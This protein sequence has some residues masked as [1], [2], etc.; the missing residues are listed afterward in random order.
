MYIDSVANM[1]GKI[2]GDIYSK[3]IQK[4]LNLDPL[5]T[6][7]KF[8][9]ANVKGANMVKVASQWE[10]KDTDL[11][12][13]VTGQLIHFLGGDYEKVIEQKEG[14]YSNQIIM[15][16]NEMNNMKTRKKLQQAKLKNIGQPKK[17]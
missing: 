17:E 14:S 15:K 12:I 10:E 3:R 8:K 4:A 6:G 16:Q 7:V 5:K 2:N 9:S 1:N 11:G 13:K